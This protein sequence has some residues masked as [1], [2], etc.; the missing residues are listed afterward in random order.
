MNT[1]SNH[2]LPS[3]I[4]EQDEEDNV[5][6]NSYG[7]EDQSSDNGSTNDNQ[8][9]NNTENRLSLQQTLAKKETKA[10]KR[11]RY[12]IFFILTVVA[13]LASVG[14]YLYSRN[15]E[16]QQ[17]YTDFDGQA[18][19]L[20]S[21]FQ[22]DSFRKLQAMESL[23]HS[24]TAYSLE[25][26]NE[27]PFV[28]M[29]N[30]AQHFE[31]Y[32]SLTN[33]ASLMVQPIVGP[34]QRYDWETYAVNQQ[35]W[36]EEDLQVRREQQEEERQRQRALQEVEDLLE[37]E[38]EEEKED[39]DGTSDTNNGT[40]TGTTIHTTGA[41]TTKPNEEIEISRYIKNYVG[42]DTSPANW[43]VG[44][45]YAPVIP[46]RWMVN[47]NRLALDGFADEVQAV[48]QRGLAVVSKVWTFQPGLDIQSTRDFTFT[49]ELLSAG[50]QGSYEPGEPIGYIHYPIFDMHDKHHRRA[51]AI[52]TATVY[53]RTYF[54]N[55]LPETVLG[56]VC[57]LE[58]TQGQKFTYMVN[59]KDAQFLGPGDLHDSKY[60]EDVLSADYASFADDEE[61]NSTNDGSDEQQQQQGNKWYTGVD[62]DTEHISYTIHVY[63]SQEMESQYMTNMPLLYAFAMIFIFLFTASI[64]ILYD[65]YVERR[66]N[67]VMNTAVKSNAVVSSLFPENVRD[68]LMEQA[69]EK[70]KATQQQQK[71][72]V[73]FETKKAWLVSNNN[74]EQGGGHG[75]VASS[76]ASESHNNGRIADRHEK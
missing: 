3:L 22:G 72:K 46:N 8:D 6:L 47:F 10:V 17:F 74:P 54:Q 30:S 75:G 61:D 48:V 49:Q 16:I 32:L 19:K 42:I 50:G 41:N 20:V 71:P 14:V 34:R 70:E 64:F 9:D 44:W 62:V 39:A 25:S 52:L 13:V 53:W 33:A 43:I 26:K 18:Q 58:N 21:G 45:Q 56:I 28:T 23:S 67:I 15:T 36:I 29:P 40:A 66:Q 11:L 35:G 59:G 7:T 57:V 1:L 4:N 12:L 60:D 2:T 69:A 5:S 65:C 37:E 76:S 51:K 38:Q 55:I 68:R 63:P 24:V 73:S 27:F 31:S